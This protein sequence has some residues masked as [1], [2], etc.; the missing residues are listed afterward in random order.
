VEPK[1]TMN[2]E[3]HLLLFDILDWHFIWQLYKTKNSQIQS[4]WERTREFGPCTLSF[5]FFF[6]CVLD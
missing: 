5:Y 3:V 1:D 4:R 6:C 2:E